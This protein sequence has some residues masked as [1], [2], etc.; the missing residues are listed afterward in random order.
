MTHEDGR[1]RGFGFVSFEDHDAAA[2]AVEE[3]NGHEVNG[4]PIFVG[5]AQKKAE[6]Q[7]RLHHRAH[8]SMTRPKCTVCIPSSE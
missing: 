2:K 8:P 4:R 3:L 1:A 7:V 5:R 6:R